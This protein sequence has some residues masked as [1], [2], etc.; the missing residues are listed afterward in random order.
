MSFK[1]IRQRK[2]ILKQFN[3]WLKEAKHAKKCFIESA[4]N[5]DHISYNHYKMR[6]YWMIDTLFNLE[7]RIGETGGLGLVLRYIMMRRI[8][9][10]F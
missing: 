1:T 7:R 10:I 3:F 8:D 6:Y 2:S 5:G 9:K 4:S